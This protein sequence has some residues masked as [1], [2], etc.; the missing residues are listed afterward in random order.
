MEKVRIGVSSCLLGEKVRYDGGH[1]LDRYITRTLGRHFQLVGVCPEVEY[2]LPVPRE[3]MH[4]SGNPDTPRLVTIRTGIDHTDGMRAW[5]ARRVRDLEKED[6]AGFIFKSRSPS[7]GMRGV[8]VYTN[9]KA[10]VNK[11]VG[12]FARTFM[13]HFPLIPVED[14]GRLNDATIRGNFIERV[15]VYHR[16]RAF[17]REG[18][19]RQ[20]LVEFHTDHKLLIM[21]H[22]PKHLTELGG[23]VGGSRGRRGELVSEYEK[24]LMEAMKLI[25]TVKKNTNVLLHIMGYFKKELSADEKEELADVIAGYHG[26]T[27]PLVA[28]VTLLKHYVRKFDQPYLKRQYY[29]NPPPAELM[30]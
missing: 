17:R 22:S 7:S 6:L 15:V 1:K 30:L 4:L 8:K 10:P 19:T 24:L 3:P 28:P 16:W 29:L 21:A 18:A 5:A 20:G 12:L 27:L 13:E 14:D 23:L 25:A 2:G 11:G 9:G 26:G